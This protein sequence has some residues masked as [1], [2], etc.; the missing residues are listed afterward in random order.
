MQFVYKYYFFQILTAQCKQLCTTC[1][2]SEYQFINYSE[3][4]SVRCFCRRPR[5]DS[6]TRSAAYR[7]G[8]F[9]VLNE[10][11]STAHHADGVE[12]RHRD[13]WRRYATGPA[14]DNV[15]RHSSP[16]PDIL[17]K[18]CPQHMNWPELEFADCS[19]RHMLFRGRECSQRTRWLSTNRPSFAAADQVVTPTR[20]SNERVV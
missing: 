1:C 15:T 11:A 2:C 8:M 16:P 14:F 4:L 17:L 18:V 6:I 7:V 19:S 13:Q 12:P 20:V 5:L 3:A 10:W 9:A